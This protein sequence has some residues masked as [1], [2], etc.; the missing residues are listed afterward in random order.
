MKEY[1]DFEDQE[2]VQI[3]KKHKKS[4]KELINQEKLSD[5]EMDELFLM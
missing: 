3:K 4:F 2:E 5:Y 1:T